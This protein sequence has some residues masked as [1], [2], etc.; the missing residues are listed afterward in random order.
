MIT[1][2]RFSVTNGMNMI[3][4]VSG[5]GKII[6]GVSGDK[7]MTRA[8]RGGGAHAYAGKDVFNYCN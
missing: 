2:N 6:A 4:T 1:E 8:P 7:D 3:D 5:R